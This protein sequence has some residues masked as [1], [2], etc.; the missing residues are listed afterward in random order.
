MFRLRHENEFRPLACTR[1]ILRIS[2]LA[3][4]RI[5]LIEWMKMWWMFEKEKKR[6]EKKQPA[7]QHVWT[8]FS[9]I[10]WLNLCAS[11]PICYVFGLLVF[12]VIWYLHWAFIQ[13]CFSISTE[14]MLVLLL[15]IYQHRV[16]NIGYADR[17]G[18][19]PWWAQATRSPRS[20][21]THGIYLFGTWRLGR[22]YGAPLRA[23]VLRDIFRSSDLR[24]RRQTNALEWIHHAA[25]ET[26]EQQTDRQ[27][28]TQKKRRVEVLKLCFLSIR[29]VNCFFS[30]WLPWAEAQPEW[31][32]DR[33]M[34]SGT[35][36]SAERSEG[37]TKRRTC[38]DAHRNSW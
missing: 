33:L 5:S 34:A 35:L 21:W 25:W 27:T 1:L 7:F 6:K 18:P 19:P 32:V 8:L 26:L 31:P 10:L 17:F 36:R 30:G 24:L 14:S 22:R 13:K 28:H 29:I 2:R 23:S 38:A 3:V 15:L 20:C 37:A 12:C 16:L 4:L 9:R 11:A